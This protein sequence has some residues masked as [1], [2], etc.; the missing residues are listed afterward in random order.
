[1]VD[2]IWCQV[3]QFGDCDDVLFEVFEG[4]V[5]CIIDLLVLVDYWCVV[6]L[7]VLF[8]CV[9]CEIVCDLLEELIVCVKVVGLCC[10]DL[11]KM[12]ILLILGMLGVV[13]CGKICDECVQLVGCVLQL[14]CG[15]FQ[16]V[17]S[18]VC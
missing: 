11:E 13:L 5:Q 3:E 4:M 16:G 12:D 10:V 7:D 9:V 15:G 14:L 8:M 2:C 17:V 1:M 6:D 18:E